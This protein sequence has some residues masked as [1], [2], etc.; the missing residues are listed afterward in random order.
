MPRSSSF[1]LY[2]LYTVAMPTHWSTRESKHVDS[3]LL[4][5]HNWKSLQKTYNL[6]TVIFLYG[7]YVVVLYDSKASSASF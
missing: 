6:T 1:L 3:M 2:K 4:V 5:T 7:N